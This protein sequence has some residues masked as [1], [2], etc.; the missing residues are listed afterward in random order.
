MVVDG[1]LGLAVAL[2]RDD[3]G[4]A[5]GVEIGQDGVGVVALIAP[6]RP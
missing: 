3:G 5:S 2:G 1:G 4:D 6:T